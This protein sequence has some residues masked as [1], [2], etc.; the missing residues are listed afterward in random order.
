MFR[1]RPFRRGIRRPVTPRRDAAL[2]RLQKAH[3][4]LAEGSY[5]EAS[6]I[7]K[8]LAEAA[9]RRGI[10]RA[11]QLFLQA[12]NAALKGGE[13]KHAVALVTHGL[14]LMARMGQ[15]R[16]LPVATRRVLDEL[17]EHGL[18]DEREALEKEMQQILAKQELSLTSIP[19]TQKPRLPT[20]CPQCGGIIRPQEVEWIDDRSAS[21]DYC[22]SI[23]EAK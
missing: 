5:K 23:L 17:Q 18:Q 2:R 14:H 11:P 8:D 22:G 19:Q 9:E 10:P 3:Q 1:R 20:K 13:P 15:Y 6:L 16:R 7:F 12:G 21:C 4:L